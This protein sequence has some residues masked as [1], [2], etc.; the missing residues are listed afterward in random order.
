MEHLAWAMNDAQ[1]EEKCYYHCSSP[2]HFI[3]DCL[4]VRVSKENMQLDCKEGMALRKGAQTP[5]DEM[6]MPKNTQDE[7]PKV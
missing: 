7:V 4:L 3:H 5:Q 6:T 1:V 2:K